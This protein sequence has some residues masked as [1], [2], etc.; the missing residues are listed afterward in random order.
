[1]WVYVGTYTAAAPYARGRAE[2]IE[3]YRLD[4]ASGALTHAFTLPGVVNPSYLA[5]APGGRALY[6]VNEAP[7]FDGRPGGGVSA[8]ARDPAS[9]ALAA[10]G[11]QPSHGTDPCYVS[12]DHTGRVALVANYT[13]GSVA[14]YPLGDDGAL[15]PAASI[16]QH[17]GSGPNPQ[18][19]AGP[20]AH[21]IQPDPAN[22]FALAADLGL[23][24]V[25]VYRLDPAR[26][27]LEPDD[28]PAAVLPAGSGPR[29]LAFH[30]A[31]RHVYVIGE[32]GSTLTACTWDGARGTLEPFQT[33]ST[34]PAGFAG[35][36][37][38]ADVHVAPS[39]RFVYGSNRGHDSIAVFAVDPATGALT[40]AGH[41][42]TGGRTPRNF[43]IDPTGAFLLAANQDTDT[44][45][46]FRLDGATGQPM[47]TGHVTSVPSPVCL[48]L[49]P[50]AE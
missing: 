10:L 4:P 27:A 14:A 3:A 6:A 1:M 24:R 38:C 46:T 13:S 47:P 44:V 21:S 16:H 17:A 40:P 23:D 15:G 29:H 37:S 26:A 45:V 9:G 18:R 48:T 35:V 22:R 32:L 2:G 20:H 41:T 42:P 43:A 25:L 5:V 31:G 34:L 33:V 39:G 12:V 7:E 49:V 11:R 30:P 36:N 19:Q 8:F 50:D 28:P